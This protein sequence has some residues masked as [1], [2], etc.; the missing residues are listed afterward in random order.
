MVE[1]SKVGTLYEGLDFVKQGRLKKNSRPSD[2]VAP[3]T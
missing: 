1:E 2:A 3:W